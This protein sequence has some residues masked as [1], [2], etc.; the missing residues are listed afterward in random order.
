MKL[1][2]ERDDDPLSPRDDDNLGCLVCFHK[3]YNLGDKTE[4]RS[5]QFDGWRELREYIEKELGGVVILPLYLMDHSGITM[6][7]GSEQF[8]ACDPAGWD[9]GQVGFVYATREAIL[10]NWMKKRLTLRLRA[11]AVALLEAE[12]KL[13]DQYLQGDIHGY[14]IEDDEGNHI[15]SCWGYYGE[16]EA[17]AEG[18]SV[19][20]ALERKAS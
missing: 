5:N 15:D 9:W 4:L 2:I 3:R 8:R 18:E 13:Y 14:I 7:T 6:R 10:K 16:A 19:M 1:R 17:R 20:K 11:Q 12:I